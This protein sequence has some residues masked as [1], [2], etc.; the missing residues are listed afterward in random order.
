METVCNRQE[1]S[2][3]T[4]LLNNIY[5]TDVCWCTQTEKNKQGARHKRMN[6][7]ME[8]YQ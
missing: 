6:I 3:P 1:W 7:R 5:E 4:T 2:M 8:V